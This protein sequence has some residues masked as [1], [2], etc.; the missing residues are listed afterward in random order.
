MKVIFKK[1]PFEEIVSSAIESIKTGVPIQKFVFTKEEYGIIFNHF[2]SQGLDRAFDR[3]QTD[4]RNNMF[5]FSDPETPPMCMPI[6]YTV[7][8]EVE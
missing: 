8:F 7:P 1:S 2:H 5:T 4:F 3:K 6:L